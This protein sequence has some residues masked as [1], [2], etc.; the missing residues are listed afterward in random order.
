MSEHMLA[1]AGCSCGAEPLAMGGEQLLPGSRMLRT[2]ALTSCLAALLGL[3]CDGDEQE[4]PVEECTPSRTMSEPC[5]PELAIDACGAGLV[6]A[7]LDGRTQPTCYAESSRL[8]GSEC[9]DDL[10]CSSHS[11]DP[12]EQRCEAS[13]YAICEVGLGCAPDPS[14]YERAC[15]TSSGISTCEKVN[16]PVNSVCTYDR[17]CKSDWCDCGLGGCTCRNS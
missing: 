11:C 2:L 15:V 14:G 4:A 8:D 3:A 1:G 13:P 12:E 7:A 17:E 16:L 5:C 9:T 10:L 6:C